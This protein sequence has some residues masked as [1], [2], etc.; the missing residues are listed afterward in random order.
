MWRLNSEM[1]ELSIHMAWSTGRP[2]FVA[3]NAMV[4]NTVG[5]SNTNQNCFDDAMPT[6][7][8]HP[9]IRTASIKITF[10]FYQSDC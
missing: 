5:F 6:M 7:V 3:A 9:R 4:V 2:V 10:F 8:L 1:G